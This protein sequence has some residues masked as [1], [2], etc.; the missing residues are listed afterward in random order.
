MTRINANL[1]PKVLLDSHLMSEY[2]ELPMVYAALRRSLDAKPIQNVIKLIPSK[3]CLN[4]GHVKFHY[5]KLTFLQDRYQRL[6]EELTIRGYKLDPNR[7]F[8]VSEFPKVFHQN[9]EMDSDA[10][11]IIVQR[12]IEKF[13][14]KPTWYKYYS[15]PISRESLLQLLGQ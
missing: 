8:D 4:F 10:K 14:M 2:R 1:P 11:S 6:I 5:N 9:W 15:K 13:D 7:T 12:I 3:F